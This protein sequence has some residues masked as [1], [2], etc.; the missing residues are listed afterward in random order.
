M[1]PPSRWPRRRQGELL[2]L[3][4]DRPTG[5][6]QPQL[7][8]PALA[9]QTRAGNPPAA[10][11]LI[12]ADHFSRYHQGVFAPLRDTLLTH[13]DHYL[14]LADLKSYLEA[15]RRLVE[16]VRRSGCLSARHHER[17]RVRQVFQRP[18][19]RRICGTDL[20]C[21]AVSRVLTK[22]ST[23]DER[24]SAVTISPRTASSSRRRTIRPRTAASSTIHPTA[25]RPTAT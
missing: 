22:S 10:L 9:L 24:K 5:R 21:G 7:V 1:E 13:G 15:D 16:T 2:P 23:A 12:F 20:E 14:H 25:A 18:H 8:Q 4:S 17:R 19:R 6:R 3:R 11:E